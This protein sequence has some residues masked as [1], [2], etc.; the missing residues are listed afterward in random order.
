MKC[1]KCGFRYDGNFCPHCGTPSVEQRGPDLENFDDT[2]QTRKSKAHIIFYC[3]AAL[4]IVAG[5]LML[6]REEYVL[7]IICLV[8][9]GVSA[10]LAFQQEDKADRAPQNRKLTRCKSCGAEISKS[11]TACPRC[12]ARQ[13][14]QTTKAAIISV[15]VVIVAIIAVRAYFFYAGLRATQKAIDEIQS[16]DFY[17]Q[18][19]SDDGSNSNNNETVSTSED[20]PGVSQEYKNALSQAETYSE[21]MNMSKQAIYDQLVSEYGG[22]FPADAAQ[23]AIDNLKADYKENALRSAK[24]YYEELNMSKESIREQLISE[25]GGQFTEEEADYAIENLE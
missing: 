7:G 21:M 18:Y 13:T 24:T 10:I 12:G 22:N 20:V 23:Y 3:I 9:G 25:Y 8:L 6:F 14:S 16:Y 11:A 1:Q 5:F 15:A 17:P 19:N 4:L 2:T